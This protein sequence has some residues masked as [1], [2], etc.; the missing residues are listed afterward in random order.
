LGDGIAVFATVV[1]GKVEK[2]LGVGEQGVGVVGVRG[3][4]DDGSCSEGCGRLTC[5][6]RP[7][8]EGCK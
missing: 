5:Q 3:L 4:E 1:I 8:K 6:I 7:W 2:L